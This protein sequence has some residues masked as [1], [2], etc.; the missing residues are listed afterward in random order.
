MKNF[1][2]LR[3]FLFMT[4]SLI[5]GISIGYFIFMSKTV[6]LII[7][8]SLAVLIAIS[9]WLFS[10]KHTTLFKI[11]L[12]S[13]L[14]LLTIFGA[15][16]F[17]LK[18][19]SFAT[20]NQNARYVSV[21]GRV[22]SVTKY[23]DYSTIILE[24]VEF[25]GAN[26]FKSKYN[27]KLTVYD[28]D[29]NFVIN[30]G[31][32]ISFNDTVYQTPLIYN[33]IFSSY[34][35]VNKIKYSAGVNANDIT[36][37]GFYQ[38][39]FERVA[40]RVRNAYEI[41]FSENER[42]I[43][44][45]LILGDTGEI[46][47]DFMDNF[48][49]S[50]VSHV[51]A[52]SGL[53]IGFLTALL[54]FI[55]KFIKIPEFIKVFLISILI[56]LYSGVCGFSPSSLRACIACVTLLV[57]RLFSFKYDA[58]SALSLSAFILLLI[59]PFNLFDVGFILSYVTVLGILLLSRSFN[60]LFRFIKF[61]KLRNSLAL[62]FS[63]FLSSTPVS[64]Y[65]FNN[66]SV[67]GILTNLIFVPI[68]SVVFTLLFVLTV[69]SLIFSYESVFLFVP[70][71][72]LKGVY[73]VFNLI[74]FR[75]F[76]FNLSIDLGATFLYYLALILSSNIINQRRITK[77]ICVVTAFMLFAVCLIVTNVI[78]NR[79]SKVYFRGNDNF[80]VSLF[81]HEGK[82]ALC[83]LG[84]QNESSLSIVNSL[85][86]ASNVSELDLVIILSNANNELIYNLYDAIPY[87]A[88]YL[89]ADTKVS[90]E[91]AKKYLG[92]EISIISPKDVYNSSGFV[93]YSNGRKAIEFS[94]NNNKVLMFGDTSGSLLA[95]GL[96]KNPNIAI[97]LTNHE[98]IYSYYQ[99]KVMLSFNENSVF[100]NAEREGFIKYILNN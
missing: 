4:I 63:A 14:I 55:F 75:I 74:N 51:F 28:N 15:L 71:V 41:S 22:E 37:L 77:V 33:E 94:V 100:K 20:N 29:L 45:A 92:A 52:V 36:K 13:I 25:V 17:T 89:G 78:D 35:L 31:D 16:Y 58:L 43:A 83:I 48:R 54:F 98:S 23:N 97:A 38:T 99:P 91:V 39:V 69:L 18:L 62:V 95:S 84:E 47:P 66:F 34:N 85:L 56:F 60:R 96:N 7:S 46:N 32:I 50:G 61:H 2:N 5:L 72:M 53:H 49:A 79:S 93:F 67:V 6:A 73:Y 88:L 12:S 24:D 9:V 27:L 68:V 80:G 19:N 44:L 57:S 90:V 30:Q 8:I 42:A 70:S 81:T 87:K 65:F 82:S 86:N 10:G 64:I 1:V 26:S 40:S 21:K 59:S 11:I 3:S 76:R